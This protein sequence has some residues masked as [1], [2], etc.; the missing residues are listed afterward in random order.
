MAKFD[1]TTIK[2]FEDAC[3]RLGADPQ[4]F[5]RKYEGFP[6]HIKALIKLEVITKALNDG[7]ENPIDGKTT[8]YYPY[9]WLY[10][11]EVAA[12]M[13]EEEKHVPRRF[14]FIK[15]D[16]SC[17]LGYAYSVNGWSFSNAYIGSRLA[18]K[19]NA[20]ADYIAIEFKDLLA[21]YHYPQIQQL[22]VQKKQLW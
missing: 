1:Y 13:T 4:D 12:E 9:V 7:W 3:L 14:T 17:G 22:E 2:S 16:G 18:C 8:V 10:R 5:Y 19:S 6:D 21:R 20:I 11:D 15:P